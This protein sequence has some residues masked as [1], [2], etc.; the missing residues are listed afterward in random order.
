MKGMT[1]DLKDILTTA[2]VQL[3]YKPNEIY[4]TYT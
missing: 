3:K 1:D 2:I 4:P